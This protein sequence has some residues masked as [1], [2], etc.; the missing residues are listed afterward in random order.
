MNWK[1]KVFTYV[2]TDLL[3]KLFSKDLI[4]FK[5]IADFIFKE[6]YLTLNKEIEYDNIIL[7]FINLFPQIK[8]L[9]TKTLLSCHEVIKIISNDE[10]PINRYILNGNPNKHFIYSNYILPHPINSCIP[11]SIGIHKN[12]KF[13]IVTSNIFYFEVF[14]DTYDF[15]APFNNQSL[16]IGFSKADSDSYSTNF[17]FKDFFGINILENRLEV[18][19][20]MIYL[21]DLFF[22]GDTV[23]IGLIY[24]EKYKYKLF[25]TKNGKKFDH[26]EEIKTQSL[27]KVIANISMSTGIDVNFGNK[28]FLFDL[29]KL[30]RSNKIIH[31]TKNNFVNNGFDLEIFNSVHSINKKISIKEYIYNLIPDK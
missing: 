23:G 8:F 5:K 14:L 1:I 28:E 11:F 21:S 31:S 3:L 20:E 6:Y 16:I 13:K 10:R 29:E 18:N 25:L 17:G 2:N 22:K 30:N 24:I 12:N 19:D 26:E 7:Q 4:Y 9:D 15:R 27:L